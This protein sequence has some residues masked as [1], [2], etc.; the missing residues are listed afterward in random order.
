MKKLLLSLG[1]M[2]GFMTAQATVYTIYDA[3]ANTTE[4][5]WEGDAKTSFTSTVTVDGKSFTLTYDKGGYKN[6]L[7]N[8][9]TETSS[10]RIYK[11]SKMSV[12]SPE[13][14][15]KGVRITMDGGTYAKEVTANS[16]WTGT[17]A[18]LI[19]TFASSD[20]NNSFGFTASTA[21]VRV[22]KIEV[23]DE[24][25][26]DAPA[27][28]EATEVN[29]IAETIA[30]KT[31]TSIKV[32]YPMTVAFVSNSNVYAFDAAG[33][34]IQ[35][36]GANSYAVNDI[37]PAGW[38]GVYKLYNNATPEIEPA[39]EFPAADGDNMF[40][41]KVVDAA[42]ITVAMVNHVINVKDVVLE[43]A[44][45]AEKANFTGT[46]NGVTLSLRNNYT[47]ASVPAGTYEMT[48][49]VTVYNNAP[50]LYVISYNEEDNSGVTSLESAEGASEYYTL[51]GVKVINPQNGLFIKI[52]NGKASKV[53]L[54]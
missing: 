30:L 29:S 50:S 47:L 18:D 45:P 49:L 6:D 28:P 39:T 36:Y 52:N 53:M 15:L 9:G 17:L 24:L 34:F 27:V 16:G 7:R 25:F 23:S 14:T 42:D 20:G 35:L 19:Y 32:E 40:V 3:S 46:S 1:L 13:V 21:Q 38:E 10:W 12:E 26:G 54:K 8:P 44:S 43:E 48:L 2:A 33:D 37:I 11:D 22:S 31:G 41:P 51:Q 5:G 4:T